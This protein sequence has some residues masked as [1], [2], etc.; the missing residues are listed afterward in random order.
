MLVSFSTATCS[1][2]NGV[3]V[4][5]YMTHSSNSYS[6]VALES[7]SGIL[8]YRLTSAHSAAS[9]SQL[10]QF[11][12]LHAGTYEETE[13]KHEVILVYAYCSGGLTIRA[14]GQFL[15]GGGCRMVVPRTDKSV[16]R[17]QRPYSLNLTYR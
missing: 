1:G 2:T 16:I 7:T 13:I 9:R 17:D 5:L 15:D 12:G 8:A 6:S 3:P 11:S 4:T 14:F 10:L